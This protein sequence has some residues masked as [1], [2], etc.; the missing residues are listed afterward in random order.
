MAVPT[1]RALAADAALRPLAVFT[2]PAA[3]RSRRGEPEG[4]PVAAAA[5][6]LGL[7]LHETASVNEDG[8]L[9]RL[10]EL[11][12]EVIVVVAFGQMLKKAV[13]GLPR[14]GCINFHPSLLPL[15]RGAAPVQ[16]AVMDGVIESGVTVMRLVRKMDAGPILA[17]QPWRMDPQL[18]AGQLLEQAAQISA[19]LV[20]E[21]LRR[22]ET[23]TP[24]PQDDARATF[25]PP[26]EKHE[27][28]L[29]F[30]ADAASLCNRVRATQPWPRAWCVARGQRLIVH[31]ALPEESPGDAAPG[32]IVRL[33]QTGMAVACGRGAAVLQVVQREGKPPLA[34]RDAAN[35]LRLA[36]GDVLAPGALAPGA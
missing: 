10:A 16:R 14:H 29:D 19:R 17:Q 3:R 36:V 13:L 32:T 5:R 35:G 21:T 23:L 2:Q 8:P 15:Y 26:L 31:K 4:S 12:P 33:D 9:A 27:G 20:P 22:L 1:L 34:A 24:L 30:A 7:E 25:A 28:A 11:A 6:E 18:D